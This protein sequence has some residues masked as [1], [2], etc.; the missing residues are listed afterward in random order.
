MKMVRRTFWLI[1]FFIV[2]LTAVA[3]EGRPADEEGKKWEISLFGGIGI[4]A[5][6]Q[7]YTCGPSY[8]RNMNGNCAQGGNIYGYI[9]VESLTWFEEKYNV[10]IHFG[11][12]CS[13]FFSREFGIQTRIG[14]FKA[15]FD[16]TSYISIT[17]ESEPN[18]YDSRVT[19]N[20]VDP[21]N[22]HLGLYYISLNLIRKIDII[23]NLEFLIS[24]GPTLWFNSFR[25]S[26]FVGVI[27]TEDGNPLDF[28]STRIVDCFI[29]P[30]KIEKTSWVVPGLNMGGGF[31][32]LLSRSFSIDY[33]F[34]YLY[35]REKSL[36]WTFGSG[37]LVGR[38]GNL[39][40]RTFSQDRLEYLQ[41]ADE[42]QLLK[43]DILHAYHS[44]GLSFRF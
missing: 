18:D 28:Q 14:R 20:Y 42:P 22:G 11:I 41:P 40:P 30:L 31:R 23:K 24:A 32:F 37:T 6:D 5:R 39:E 10:G 15:T 3:R 29:A 9:V 16:S 33:D 27:D 1:L 25:A 36:G 38:L 21:G 35:G 34:R 17:M 44:L 7:P 19:W 13:Y 43:V 4:V 12:Q 8:W 26:A 2:L